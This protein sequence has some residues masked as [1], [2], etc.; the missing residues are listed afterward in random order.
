MTEAI[1][2]SKPDLTAHEVTILRRYLTESH[3]F[4]GQEWR[5]MRQIIDKLAG[6]EV[7][8]GAQ[9]AIASP[10][11]TARLSTAR[12]HTPS[13]QNWQNCRTQNRMD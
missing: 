8:F 9:N 2:I 1:I 11:S 12:M 3:L 5:D 4:S 6:S 10:N 7:Q 13:W